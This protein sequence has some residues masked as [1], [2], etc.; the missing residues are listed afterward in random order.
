MHELY[1]VTVHG[2][3]VKEKC[4]S[5]PAGD[6]HDVSCFL[7]DCG[8]EGPTGGLGS[9]EAGWGLGGGRCAGALARPCRS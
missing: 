9:A 7:P 6:T 2:S 5:R 1:V 4:A 3:S 8:P